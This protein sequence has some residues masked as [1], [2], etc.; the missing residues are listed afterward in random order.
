[1]NYLYYRSPTRCFRADACP[2]GIGGYSSK[3][4]A[5]RWELPLHLFWRATLNMLEF[6]AS[7]IGPWI[8]LIEQ[9]LP[10][11]SC[12]LSMSDS[13]TSNGWLKKSNFN[14]DDEEE[15]AAHLG[16]KLELARAHS[17]RL[18][19]NDIKEYGQWF[20]GNLNNVSDCLSRDFHLN[21]TDITHLLF[22]CVPHQLPPS[23]AI[24]PLPQEIVSFLYAWLL[25]MPAKKPSQERRT[26]SGLRPGDDG[27]SSSK[28]SNA[29]KNHTSNPSSLP[30]EQNLS[31]V[32]PR[33]SET[34]NILHR[35]TTSWLQ[36]QSV[37]PWTMWLRPSGTTSSLIRDSTRT[38][39]LHAFYQDSTRAI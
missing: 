7:T 8:D 39:S 1:M 3:G 14:D 37:L 31:V 18:F 6:V 23:F 25:K 21:D 13:T 15:E 16:C 20:A 30:T 35:L 36:E 11:L 29:T 12:I 10:P 2:W 38:V 26:R 27:S 22:S 33:P 24:A 32:L 9:N 17:T 5:W 28:P 4:R 19:Q 34:P